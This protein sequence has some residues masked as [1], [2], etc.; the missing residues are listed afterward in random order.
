MHSSWIFSCIWPQRPLD[1]TENQDFQFFF[2]FLVYLFFQKKI[3]ALGLLWKVLKPLGMALVSIYTGLEEFIDL[4]SNSNTWF[5]SGRGVHNLLQHPPSHFWNPHVESFQ[6]LWSFL[7]AASNSQDKAQENSNRLS[8][9]YV[10]KPI[11][12][13]N[14]NLKW[15]TTTYIKEG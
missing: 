3:Y 5:L 13:S 9:K 7:L 12:S 6:N 10:Q 8:N 4:V 15:C 2:K 1:P 11:L 14:Q